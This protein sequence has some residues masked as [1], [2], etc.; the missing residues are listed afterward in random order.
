MSNVKQ[1]LKRLDRELVEKF[2]PKTKKHEISRRGHKIMSSDKLDR[3]TIEHLY[4]IDT[5]RKPKDWIKREIDD[6]NEKIINDTSEEDAALQEVFRVGSR[7][8]SH[9]F[10]IDLNK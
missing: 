6:H 9:L 7:G 4:K 8:K 1:Q 3:R 10:N 2:N 5:A